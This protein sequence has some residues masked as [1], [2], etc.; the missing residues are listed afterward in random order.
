MN[1]VAGLLLFLS[2][3]GARTAAPLRHPVE[4]RMPDAAHKGRWYFAGSGHA[5]YCVGP[6]LTITQP[7]GAFQR[8][9]TFC[10]GNKVIVALK[11]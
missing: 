3:P 10:R 6:V 11:D 4:Q 2:L 5:V 1:V 9:A 8:V 7:T